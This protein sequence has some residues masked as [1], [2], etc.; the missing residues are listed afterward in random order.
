[1]FPVATL[2]LIVLVY[3]SEGA[4]TATLSFLIYFLI[5]N[6]S[7]GGSS[8][9]NDFGRVGEVK[10]ARIGERILS[11]ALNRQRRLFFPFF[12]SVLC[13]PVDKAVGWRASLARGLF[14]AWKN[15]P[16]KRPCPNRNHLIESRLMDAIS[17][18]RERK[19]RRDG[20]AGGVRRG[21]AVEVQKKSFLLSNGALPA[22]FRPFVD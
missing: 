20:D 11:S 17:R 9:L 15:W 21:R 14:I 2:H 18:A 7:L 6:F 1:M 10:P 16:V 5:S 19:R 4:S 3:S 8:S 22:V 13:N 12:S